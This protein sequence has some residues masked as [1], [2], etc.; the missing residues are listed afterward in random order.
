MV[1]EKELLEIIGQAFVSLHE[2]AAAHAHKARW[3]D[4][5]PENILFLKEW[6]W[7]L[8]EHWVFLHVVRNPLDTLA[9]IKEANFPFAIPS[10][11]DGRI[12]FYRR[13]TRAGLDFGES[14][15]DRYVRLKYEDLVRSPRA[16]LAALMKR[17]GE[18]FEE[19]QLEFNRFP[20]QRGLEDPKVG[21][22]A[23]IHVQSVGRWPSLLNPEEA[24]AIWCQTRELWT[25][26]DPNAPEKLIIER[27]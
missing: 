4:K 6:G 21:Q 20:H 3:A 23:E 22:T 24:R 5:N 16:V 27:G 25:R 13:Y 14:H 18:T 11:L 12:A 19:D 7:L 9:S 17:L 1:P 10:D 8:G 26:I 2:R 15:A